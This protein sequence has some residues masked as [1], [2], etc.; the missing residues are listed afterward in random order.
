VLVG[1]PGPGRVYLYDPIAS[2]AGV[3][4]AVSRLLAVTAAQCGNGLVEATEQC[5]DGND[6]DTDDCRSDCTRGPCCTLDAIASRCD[7]GNPCTKDIHD[8]AVGC[9]Y[10]PDPAAGCCQSDADCGGQQCRL[11]V[12]CFLFDW[13]CCAE[14]SRCIPSNPEC[15]AKTC[16]DAAFCQCAGKLDCAGE[17][18]PDDLK[19]PFD[20]ACNVLR[21]AEENVEPDGTPV[22][23]DEIVIARQQ[24]RSARS[25]LK[26]AARMARTMLRQGQI[27]KQ[28]RK[29]VAEQVRVVRKAIPRGKKLRRCLKSGG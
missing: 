9:R 21:L 5:D 14:G 20:D 8:A 27:T 7:D 26:K 29:S 24:T 18:I 6:V 1:S 12:G 13:D 3:A 17:A 16:L 23:K 19:K 28:C 10:E 25:G 4:R 11:C 2:P 15:A 22:T